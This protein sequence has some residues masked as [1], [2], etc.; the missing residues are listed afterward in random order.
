MDGSGILTAVYPI[1]YHAHQYQVGDELPTNDPEMTTL[2]LEAGTAAYLTPPVKEA[3]T[4][5]PVTAEGGLPGKAVASESDGE[6]LVGKV[7]KTA[8]R[9]RKKG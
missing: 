3:V 6:D 7:P 5:K 2:W 9:S 8:A 1:L 4:V